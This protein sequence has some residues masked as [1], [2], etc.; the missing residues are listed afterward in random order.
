[1]YMASRIY[2]RVGNWFLICGI[3]RAAV[4]VAQHE[5][6]E[7]LPQ[8]FSHWRANRSEVWSRQQLCAC[9]S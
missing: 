7:I 4:C 6:T 8:R 5:T 9:A 1:M 2:D 3:A